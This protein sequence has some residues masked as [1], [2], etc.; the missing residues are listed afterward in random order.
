MLAILLI[1]ITGGL[2]GYLGYLVYEWSKKVI[3]GLIV[4]FLIGL[5]IPYSFAVFYLFY[6]TLM[7]IVLYGILVKT[8]KAK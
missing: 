5:M 2:S 4:T 7:G 1:S 8:H 6:G 3:L